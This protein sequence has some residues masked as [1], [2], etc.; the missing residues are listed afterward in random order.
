[1]EKLSSLGV[2]GLILAITGF[3]FVTCT[4]GCSLPNKMLS[5]SDKKRIN[6]PALRFGIMLFAGG[7]GLLTWDLIIITRRIEPTVELTPASIQVITPTRRVVSEFASTPG[8]IVTEKPSLVTL[9]IESI[10]AFIFAYE[11][12]GEQGF[13]G[14]LNLLQHYT[15]Y[16]QT[17]TLDYNL[18]EEE[19]EAYVG[20][21]F[22]FDQDQNLLTYGYVQITIDFGWPDTSC[23]FYIKD[24]ADTPK[25]MNGVSIGQVL[26]AKG[27][28]VFNLGDNKYT[29]TIPLDTNFLDTD[30]S[31]ITE[32]G[33]SLATP[34]A[35]GDKEII[36]SDIK[37]ISQ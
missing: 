6:I 35:Q 10:P 28:S 16:G 29:F 15:V 22:S 24:I 33:F 12:I 9:P 19:K 37:F 7:L 11:G 5:S 13:A 23:R 21:V 30:F 4:L 20:L 18:P 32:I 36:F 2:G 1:M 8:I 3:V 26:S 34:S 31:A 27:A 25:T 17:Y 14:T